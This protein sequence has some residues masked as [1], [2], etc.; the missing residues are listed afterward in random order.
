MHDTDY[1]ILYARIR[2]RPMCIDVNG[3]NSIYVV[4]VQMPVP[5]Y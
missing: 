1:D 3:L 4:N 2:I 5:A